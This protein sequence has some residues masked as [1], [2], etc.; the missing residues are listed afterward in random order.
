MQRGI[1]QLVQAA[2]EQYANPVNRG[3]GHSQPIDPQFEQKH[4]RDHGKFSS[5]PGAKGQPKPAGKAAQPAAQAPAKATPQASRPDASHAA[6]AISRGDDH[7]EHVVAFAKS[8][9]AAGMKGPEVRAHVQA[10]V[11]KHYPPANQDAKNTQARYRTPSGEYTPERKLLHDRI[12]STMLHGAQPAEGKPEAHFMGGGPAS[13][14]STIIKSGIVQWP[15][16]HVLVDPDWAKWQLPEMITGTPAGD[17]EAASY[18]HMES[19]DIGDKGRAAVYHAKAHALVDG[20]GDG[21]YD[22]MAERVREARSAGYAAHAHYVT[23]STEEAIK[24]S[25]VRAKLEKRAVPEQAIRE[26]HRSVSQIALR[27][28]QEGL[29]DTAE[30]WDT[31]VPQGTPPIRIASAQGGKIEIHDQNRWKTFVDKAK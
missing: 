2:V 28:M 16:G 26:K 30:V 22:L 8:A 1:K 31:E 27:A 7:T 3:V 29:F 25:E 13:G 23:I 15:K 4:P 18:V 10:A 19:V 5:K 17:D 12:V 6:Q 11:D 9:L 24:R 20:T 14:K 21:S